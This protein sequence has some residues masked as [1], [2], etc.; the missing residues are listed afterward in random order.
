MKINTLGL[1]YK[2]HYIRKLNL[3]I[4]IYLLLENP[5]NLCIKYSFRYENPVWD[6]PWNKSMT[7]IAA[8]P[9][10]LKCFPFL[11]I[12][13][14]SLF[15]HVPPMLLLYTLMPLS[16]TGCSINTC[17]SIFRGSEDE[18]T[19]EQCEECFHLMGFFFSMCLEGHHWL[20]KVHKGKQV[21]EKKMYYTQRSLTFWK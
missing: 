10:T 19:A 15:Y 14:T 6:L 20:L 1:K 9:L 17:Y 8:F 11:D 7:N 2:R 12:H 3:G 4:Y 13:G 18:D 16:Q 21:N 5:P